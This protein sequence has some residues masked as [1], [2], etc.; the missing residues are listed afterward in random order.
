MARDIVRRSEIEY[1]EAWIREHLLDPKK[2]P[3]SFVYGMDRIDGEQPGWR[4][5]RECRTSDDARTEHVTTLAHEATGLIVRCVAVQYHAFPVVEWTVWFEHT[6]A[7]DSPPLRCVRA[8]DTE[9]IEP[10]ATESAELWWKRPVRLDYFTG[11]YGFPDSYEPKTHYFFDEAPLVVSP[12]NGHPL[13]KAFPYFRLQGRERGVIFVVSWQGQWEATFSAVGPKR[14]RM[15]GIRAIA[16]QQTLH[17]VLRPGEAI[18]TPMIV[19]LPYEGTDEVRAQNLWR[20]WYFAHVLPRPRGERIR[21]FH[22]VS[23]YSFVKLAEATAEHQK[24]LIDR[25]V[26]H[27]IVPDCLWIDAGW[28][29]MRGKSDW[30]T[31]GTWKPHAEHYPN[32]V[33][34]VS[35][36]ARR[37]EIKTI[38]WFEPE[39]V[40]P[41]TELAVEH[42]EWILY[43]KNRTPSSWGLVDLG[44][45]AAR[46]WITARMSALIESEKVD[47]YR[48][49]MN[50]GPL[51]FW[52]DNEEPERQGIRENH[53]CTGYL[54]FWDEILAAHPGLL[55]DSCAGG[56]RRNDLETMRRSVPL[57]K[58]DYD[59]GDMTTKHGM[60]HSLFQ[61]LPF[62]GSGNGPVERSDRYTYRGSLLLTYSGGDDVFKDDFDFGKLAAQI[63][64]WRETAHCLYGDYYPLTPYSRDDRD[65]IGWQFHLDEQDEGVVQ[66]FRRP[67]AAYDRGTFR[68]RGLRAEVEYVLQDYNSGERKSIFGEA[69]MATGL[70]V[71]L[72]TAPDAALYHYRRQAN[73]TSP[74]VGSGGKGGEEREHT[75]TRSAEADVQQES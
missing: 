47:V 66:I 41:G 15:D 73:E 67:K 1:V 61:W 28:Y 60:H 21:P 63:R 22:S 55:I 37:H 36:Y 44:N 14:Y 38:L 45:P 69:L 29:D 48:Q 13:D 19:L 75:A 16:G 62:F 57:H 4:F 31:V 26:A 23:C 32:G 49:D 39:R 43:R 53:Y 40:A 24:R 20:R 17:A 7:D 35:D 12:G 50:A 5:E 65:W 51:G 42:P 71:T 56:G 25:Y 52:R 33:R 34:E 59:S 64:E 68:L 27:G 72:D 2:L 70:T 10:P 54:R 58:T 8:V 46:A 30:E 11:D 9:L 3:Y 74:A 18:R 6:G